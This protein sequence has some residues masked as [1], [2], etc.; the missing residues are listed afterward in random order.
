MDIYGR[1]LFKATVIKAHEEPYECIR[2]NIL[3]LADNIEKSEDIL[4]NNIR[5][6]KRHREYAIEVEDF[7]IYHSLELIKKKKLDKYGFLILW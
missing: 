6:W 1:S 5:G 2:M 4:L 7:N 3:I